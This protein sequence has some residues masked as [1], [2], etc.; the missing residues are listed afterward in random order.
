VSTALPAV[1]SMKRE[2]AY[3]APIASARIPIPRAVAAR[4]S[5]NPRNRARHA[6]YDVLRRADGR[7][8][9]LGSPFPRPASAPIQRADDTGRNR[10][11]AVPC[12]ILRRAVPYPLL[13]A[14]TGNGAHGKR[15][16]GPAACGSPHTNG[17]S[18]SKVK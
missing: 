4:T 8:L 7:P 17:R 3:S 11:R 6:L 13:P 12:A 16:T 2:T 1:D 15:R 10:A 9:V 5:W 14:C 18:L